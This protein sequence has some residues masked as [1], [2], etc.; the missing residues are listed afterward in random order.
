M[1]TLLT[2]VALIS[3]VSFRA[4]SQALDSYIT[5]GL[6]NNIVLQQKKVGLDKAMLSLKIANGMFM[7]SVSLLGNY[8]S[9]NGGRSISLPVGDMLNPV[10]QTLNQLTETNN[11]PQIENVNQNFF[12]KDFYDMRV[13]ASAPIVN[14]DLIY[15]KKIQQQQLV[16][17]EYE[18]EI[19]KRELV[20]NMKV[21][22]YNYLSA[23]EAI[24]IY[25]S[26][27]TRAIESK[28]V[29]ESLLQ[30]GRGLP[31][32]VIRS[33][34]ELE[35][36]KAHII[37]AK[38]NAKNAQMYFNFLLNRDA[39]EEIIADT[40]NL[41]NPDEINSLLANDAEISQREELSQLRQVSSIHENILRSKQ[42]FWSPKVSAFADVGSQAQNWQFN[43][44]SKYYLLGVQLEVPLFGGFTNRYKIQQARLD[45]NNTRLT[46]TQV[47]RQ[48]E[49]SKEIAKNGIESA[50]Q[51]YVSASAQLEAA[52]SYMR[53][54]EKGYKEGVNTFIESIDAR[55]QLTS[56]QLQVA[57]NR[58]K[59]LIA[60]ANFERETSSFKFN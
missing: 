21:A 19:Y 26:A 13:R 60:Q 56:A 40:N 11:F 35:T 48:L 27:L 8:T 55:N 57:I 7:P 30:N 18:V 39:S 32:Y 31:A 22:Y 44:Q 5:T 54:I 28:R 1:R 53:L 16:L 52:Q 36:I 12:P 20:K 25:E 41:V 9:G 4:S 3:L 47:S 38:N 51:N 10:Y 15:N 17:Q 46:T 2:I 49:M 45:V 6:N 37:E 33:E 50:L 29:N 59:L 42:Y 24:G 23:F 58:Y 43:D 34:S 14:S